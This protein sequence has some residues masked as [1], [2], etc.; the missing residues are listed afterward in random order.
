MSGL[1]VKLPLSRDPDDGLSLNKGFP[2]LVKQNLLMILLTIPG[3]RMM[4]PEFGV[5]LKRYLFDNDSPA[6]RSEL[7]SKIRSQVS[8]YLPYINITSL[9]FK[10]SNQN[11]DIDRNLLIIRIDYMI[12]PLNILDQ[13]NVH[14]T[15]TNITIF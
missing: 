4:L 10:T 13:L 11:N 12:L 7:S 2:E 8:R 14:H 6:L 15:D 1:S 9:S 5:G 3:E